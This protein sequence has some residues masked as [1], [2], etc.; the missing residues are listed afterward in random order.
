MG[1]FSEL[2]NNFFKNIIEKAKEL[3]YSESN[4]LILQG[5]LNELK[6]KFPDVYSNLISCTHNRDKRTPLEYGQDLVA[7]WLFED[8]LVDSLKKQGFEISLSGADSGREILATSK[9]S[10]NSDTTVT[11]MGKSLQMEIMS[12]YTGYW[13][14]TNKIDLRDEKYTKLKRT[15][16]LFLGVSTKDTTYVM[17][18]FS[19]NVNH[20]YIDSHRPYGGKPCYSISI[21]ASQL[22]KFTIG[23]IINDIISYLK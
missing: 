16:S 20:Q 4:I 10:S 23:N 7:S 15:S 19:Q 6:D 22:K 2:S 13:A 9:V 14:R 18:D 12:D 11:Y 17:I 3:N 1:A 5:N 8:C 21:T